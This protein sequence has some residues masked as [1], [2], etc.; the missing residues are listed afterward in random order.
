MIVVSLALAFYLA[1]QEPWASA[2]PPAEQRAAIATAADLAAALVRASSEEARAELLASHTHL[3]GPDLTKA[4][5]AEGDRRRET[6]APAEAL[7]A[8]QLAKTLSERSGD[9]A[10]LALALRSLGHLH[11]IQGRLDESLQAL[12]RSLELSTAGGDQV[13]V[14]Q[15]LNG[16]ANVYNLRGDYDNALEHYQRTLDISEQLGLKPG[17][18]A[19]SQNI[20]SVLSQRGEHERALEHYRRAVALHEEQGN[21]GNVAFGLTLIGYTY[22]EQG[23]LVQAE[24]YYRKSLA[25]REAVGAREGLALTLDHIGALYQLQGRYRLALAHYERA[26]AINQAVGAR[27]QEATNWANI[28]IVHRLQGNLAQAHACFERALAL[29][30]EM[31]SKVHVA[32]TLRSIGTLERIEGRYAEALGHFQQSLSLREELK[33]PNGI[34]A[35]LQSLGDVHLLLGAHAEALDDYGKSLSLAEMTGQAPL[36]AEVRHGIA[37]VRLTERRYAEAA[38]EAERAAAMSR[39]MGLP[40]VLWPTLVTAGRAHRAQGAD[41]RAREAFAEAIATIEGLRQDV[42]GGEAQ[43]ERF[44]EDK[45][46]AYHEMVDLLVA[47][48]DRAAAFAHAERA[49][50]RVLA[51]VMAHGRTEVTRAMTPAEREEEARLRRR[52]VTLNRRIYREALKSE[53][54]ARTLASVRAELS[55]VRLERE[56]FETRLFAAHP[57]LQA[58]RGREPTI[59]LAEAVDVVA[60]P[61]TAVLEYLVT[62]KN[63]FLFLLTPGGRRGEAPA[64]EVHTLGA[65]RAKLARMTENLRGRLAQRD[66]D[67]REPA[68]ALH[69]LVLGPVARRLRQTTALLILPD[70]PLWELPFQALLSRAGRYVLEDHVIAYAPSLTVLRQMRRLPRER[71]RGRTVLALGNPT[72]DGAEPRPPAAL[73]SLLDP[74][75]EAEREVRALGRLYGPGRSTVFVGREAREDRTKVEAGRH[76]ILHFATHSFLDDTSPLYSQIVL[77]PTA[78]APAAA[79]AADDGLLEARE[80]M[81]LDVQADLAVLSACETGRGRVGAGEGVIGLSWAFFVAGCPTAVVS[82]WK[83]HSA[84]TSDLML[85][86]HRRLRAGRSTAAALREAA[87]AVKRDARYRHPFY[88]AAFVAVGDGTRAAPR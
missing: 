39:E 87:L 6:G 23:D 74:L 86:F 55:S 16:I 43:A 17:I 8:Y 88:W 41:A 71:Q 46:A 29:H 21:K 27:G 83:V 30:R 81:D 70:G 56:A 69:R 73:R 51:D 66:L 3:A 53:M 58:Q 67:F 80:I 63:A 28:G 31:G 25:L 79:G 36:V 75:P 54:D 59:T 1:V 65:G 24:E 19:A 12:Q 15:A 42:S 64:L 82:Q 32:D 11:R 44:F 77:A 40:D 72:A 7:A 18:A 47:E 4:L 50:A 10:A 52:A 78:G 60:E 5:V 9:A 35:A 22:L 84:S 85:A 13:G 38:E 20:G 61:G 76:R 2:A 34:A 45:L 68:A 26:L 62:E 37:R 49:R 57:K 14:A 33:S 48:G